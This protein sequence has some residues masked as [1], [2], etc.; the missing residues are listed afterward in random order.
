MLESDDET[1][2]DDVKAAKY[3]V[4]YFWAAWS[5]P[6]KLMSKVL[7]DIN[8]KL[9]N[10]NEIKL[11]KINSDKSPQIAVEQKVSAPPTLIFFKDG[12][13]AERVTGIQK[14]QDIIS[15]VAGMKGKK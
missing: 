7:D 12:E 2:N 6:C 8:E 11:I 14:E 1:F 9:K 4:A 5:N 13:E 10:Y 15:V 3:V